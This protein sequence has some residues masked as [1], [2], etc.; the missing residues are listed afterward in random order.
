MQLKPAAG[1]EIV[2]VVVHAPQQAKQRVHPQSQ[3]RKAHEQT[4][5]APEPR[6]AADEQHKLCRYV[7]ERSA[8]DRGVQPLG[9][10]KREPRREPGE[11]AVQRL[12]KVQGEKAHFLRVMPQ[13]KEKRDNAS[14]EQGDHMRGGTQGKDGGGAA[15]FDKA[16]LHGPILAQKRAACNGYARKR[17][18][19]ISIFSMVF[20]GSSCYNCKK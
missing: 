13:G 7:Q 10:R 6:R 1:D 5:Q 2:A 9:Q 18:R 19:D 14:S 12:H 8:D 3:R 11:D 16:L 17:R 20:C 4:V 15:F